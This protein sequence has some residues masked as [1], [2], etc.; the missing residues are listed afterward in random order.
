MLENVYFCTR[1]LW[2]AF[3]C[4]PFFYVE[5]YHSS[6][7]ARAKIIFGICTLQGSTA[8]KQLMYKNS[9]TCLIRPLVKISPNCSLVSTWTME[10]PGRHIPLGNHT[11]S[12]WKC[13]YDV[14][15]ISVS[16]Q[17]KLLQYPGYAIWDIPIYLIQVHHRSS[18]TCTHP[19]SPPPFW[20]HSL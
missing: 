19:S 9:N 17:Y 1:G 16:M 10:I 20:S 11:D 4:G 12:K 14:H 15:L 5:T 18:T 13:Y 7:Q 6:T 3:K 8:K 2:P